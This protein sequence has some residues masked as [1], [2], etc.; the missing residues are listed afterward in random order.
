MRNRENIFSPK[1]N[2]NYK[3][4]FALVIL[5]L[6]D[7]IFLSG[8][9]ETFL[10]F[11]VGI[12]FL[13]I[14]LFLTWGWLIENIILSK[15]IFSSISNEGKSF[16][17]CFPEDED[18]CDDDCVQSPDKIEIVFF[19]DKKIAIFKKGKEQYVKKR[20]EE[21]E[22]R[23]KICSRHKD[24]FVFEEMDLAKMLDD[25]SEDYIFSIKYHSFFKKGDLYFSLK[26]DKKKFFEQ[27][28]VQKEEE[29]F[30][31][32][33]FKKELDGKIVFLNQVLF[34]YPSGSIKIKKDRLNFLSESSFFSIE[35]L[36]VVI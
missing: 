3:V 5:G 30:I 20:K 36:E 11:C 1:F 33:L 8:V 14:C 22:K 18:D 13:I 19:K 27:I 34:M 9:A 29:I 16:V 25:S 6:F 15:Y 4:F 35:E 26:I 21:I 28:F 12:I 24:D 10:A 2:F 32:R 17:N 31:S 7:L 23:I